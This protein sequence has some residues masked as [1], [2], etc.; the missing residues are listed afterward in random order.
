MDAWGSAERIMSDIQCDIHNLPWKT[1]PPGVSRKTGK[2]YPAFQ[3][4]Q[5]KDCKERPPQKTSAVAQ[6]NA[7]SGLPARAFTSSDT[8]AFAT[9][10]DLTQAK[11][12]ILK[13]LRELWKK[14]DSDNALIIEA[15]NGGDIV[16]GERISNKENERIGKEIKTRK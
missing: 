6:P 16:L 2:P 12:E 9:K 11:E 14:I 10:E 8:S 3:V 13:G 15:A 1:V 4:C 7:N 5:V